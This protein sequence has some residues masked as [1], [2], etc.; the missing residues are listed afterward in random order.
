MRAEKSKKVD[1]VGKM[2]D[3]VLDR[4]RQLRKVGVR[5]YCVRTGGT[6][7]GWGSGGASKHKIRPKQTSRNL[8]THQPHQRSEQAHYSIVYTMN[9]NKHKNQPNK[10]KQTNAGGTRSFAPR[11]WPPP[12]P[13]RT[14]GL[15]HSLTTATPST[16]TETTK[17]TKK[18]PRRQQQQQ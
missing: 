7:E 18:K 8:I 17:T 11:T 3:A 6:D 5:R 16:T 13:S 10:K 14:C 4:D 12:S 15:P 2:A 1:M 9:Q